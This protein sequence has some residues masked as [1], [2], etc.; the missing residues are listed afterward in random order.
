MPEKKS[1]LI[2]TYSTPSI[3]Q[4]ATVIAERGCAFQ[5]SVRHD[6]NAPAFDPTRHAGLIIMGD[7]ESDSDDMDEYGDE[8]RWL[9]VALRE[10]KPVLGICHGAQ[11]LAIGLGT[12]QDK[13]TGFKDKGMPEVFFTAKGVTDPLTKHLLDFP[14]PFQWHK[15]SHTAPAVAEQLIASSNQ[16]RPHCDAFRVGKYVYGLQFHPEVSVE[17]FRESTKTDEAW[18]PVN[19]SDETLKAACGAGKKVLEAWVDLTLET[20]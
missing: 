20:C 10:K 2:V 5:S 13:R 3:D 11:L 7:N 12:K 4:L 19:A 18:E 16:S 14:Y 17:G 6:P 9:G 8:T 15:H 1:F